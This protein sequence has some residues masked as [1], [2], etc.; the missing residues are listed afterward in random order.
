MHGTRRIFFGSAAVVRQRDS[1]VM[2]STVNSIC[3]SDYAFVIWSLLG[4]VE[5]GFVWIDLKSLTVHCVELVIDFMNWST[6][7][8]P[9]KAAFCQ[10][11]SLKYLINS[12]EMP[13][14]QTF[15]LRSFFLTFAQIF[16]S[17]SHKSNQIQIKRKQTFNKIIKQ[18]KRHFFGPA[19]RL[20][21][22]L[23]VN[24]FLCNE[25]K[26]VNNRI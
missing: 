1:F 15:L 14:P 2:L 13:P 8:Y 4:A 20:W 5:T 6:K 23:F 11:L 3:S 25:K 24:T 26:K 19:T 18:S 9:T 12:V 10:N 17:K 7:K 16:H 22:N 21:S